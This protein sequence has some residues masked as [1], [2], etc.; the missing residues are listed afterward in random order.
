MQVRVFEN[1]DALAEMSAAVIAKWLRQVEGR[2]ATLGLAGGGTPG[3]TYSRLR[4]E[5]VPWDRVDAWMGDE[6][7]VPP[8]HPYNN[9]RMA[10]RILLDHVPAR[11]HPVP[12]EAGS[13][14]AAALSYEETLGEILPRED[15]RLRPDVVILGLGEDGHCASLFPGSEVLEVRDRIYVASHVPRIG[16]WRLTATL[17]LLQAAHRIVFIVTGA[18]KASAVAGTLEGPEDGS[19]GRQVLEGP[20]AVT[21]FLDRAAAADL[22]HTKQEFV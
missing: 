22:R 7:W 21:W 19:P 5:D 14:Q 18:Q 13:P 8:D 9:G 10:R 3:T 16:R 2:A 11:F 15:G 4:D 1:P 6:R 12:W 20:S 17:P